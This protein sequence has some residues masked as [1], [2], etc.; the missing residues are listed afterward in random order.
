[1]DEAGDHV[2]GGPELGG[3]VKLPQ[4]GIKALAKLG[5]DQIAESFDR[6]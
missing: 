4:V 1:M 2:W 6:V 5:L 3:G